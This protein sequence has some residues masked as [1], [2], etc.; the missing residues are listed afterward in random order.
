MSQ[1]SP[2]EETEA[3]WTLEAVM[4]RV[5]EEDGSAKLTPES[6]PRE[7]IRGVTYVVGGLLFLVVLFAV[8][9]GSGFM[10]SADGAINAAQSDGFSQVKIVAEHRVLASIT[11][12]CDSSDA[13]GFEMTAV[14]AAGQKVNL[15]VC[16]GWP[17]K[18]FTV[19]FR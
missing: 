14:N 5:V 7:I 13:A 15:T 4:S 17:F 19:R 8:I 2:P 16:G 1:E 10:V 3:K 18:G 12:G 6:L 11:A 9:F